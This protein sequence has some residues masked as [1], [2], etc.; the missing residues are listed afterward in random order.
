M[1]GGEDDSRLVD[2]NVPL[3]VPMED[4]PGLVDKSFSEFVDVFLANAEV[5][6]NVLEAETHLH[7]Y[8]LIG[9]LVSV[10]I[11]RMPYRNDGV[12]ST[13]SEKLES[14]FLSNKLRKANDEYTENLRQDETLEKEKREQSK[15]KLTEESSN[16]AENKEEKRIGDHF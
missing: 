1:I 12:V 3:N 7:Q 10:A 9:K 14:V 5:I 13:F 15:G 11:R 16:K 2:K 6:Y 8:Q 4:A